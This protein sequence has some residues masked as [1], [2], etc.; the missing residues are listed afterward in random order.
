MSRVLIWKLLV[1]CLI[2]RVRGWNPFAKQSTRS[3]AM[4]SNTTKYA[5]APATATELKSNPR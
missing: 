3:F 1:S 4:Q 5:N 2:S